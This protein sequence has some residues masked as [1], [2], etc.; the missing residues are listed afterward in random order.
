MML[1]LYQKSLMTSTIYEMWQSRLSFY[2]EF[3]EKLVRQFERS[4]RV[5]E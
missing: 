1:I 3:Y 5:L 2:I 4:E